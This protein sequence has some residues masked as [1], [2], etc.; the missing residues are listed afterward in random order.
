[1]SMHRTQVAVHGV[2]RLILVLGV[3]LLALLVATTLLQVLSRYV[4]SK[5]LDWTEEAARYIFIWVAML[6]AGIAAKDRAHFFVD[7][8][9]ERMPSTLRKYVTVLIGTI[10]SIFLLVI[11]WAAL[12]LALSNGVQDSPVLTIPMSIPYFAIPV[13]LGLMTLFSV[14]DT[15]LTIRGSRRRDRLGIDEVKEPPSTPAHR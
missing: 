7:L 12:E 8:I 11:S 10:S 1:M 6:G 2:W 9:L 14:S 4:L 15:V 13:G 5:P 3:V